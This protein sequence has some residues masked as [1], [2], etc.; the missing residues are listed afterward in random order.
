MDTP[1]FRSSARLREK[2]QDTTQLPKHTIRSQKQP[3]PAQSSP[4]SASGSELLK[5]R[6][7]SDEP[8]LKNPK[9]FRHDGRVKG[10]R[11][12]L[13]FMTEIPMDVLYEI[14]NALE[15][16]DLLY[17]SWANK[18]LH[19]I[20]MGKSARYI[21]ERV[22][23]A[24]IPSG[25]HLTIFQGFEALYTSAHPPPP[26]PSDLNLAQYTRLLFEKR[27][28]VSCR[29]TSVFTLQILIFSFYQP[30]P[31]PHLFVGM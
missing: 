21:W 2:L 5:R 9:I 11:G 24:L 1:I 28:M 16:I 25:P 20:V 4:A 31:P 8:K 23:L 12:L 6:K 29:I 14:L 18:A 26:C 10:R 22:R 15:P 30:G 27:C 3:A 7:I 19:S 17:L 13:K